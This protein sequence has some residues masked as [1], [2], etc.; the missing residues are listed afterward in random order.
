VLDSIQDSDA[1]HLIAVVDAVQLRDRP[2]RRVDQQRVDIVHYA[3]FVEESG[4]LPVARPRIAH[5]VAEIINP[6]SVT[7]AASQRA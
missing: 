4:H 3:A 6:I 1:H 7:R 2:A 5:H